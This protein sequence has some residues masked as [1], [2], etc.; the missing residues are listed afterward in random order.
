MVI[1]AID[2][3]SGESS[4]VTIQVIPGQ[5]NPAILDH[6][7]L[8]N[9]EFL[10]WLWD[11]EADFVVI[12]TLASNGGASQEV[13][14]TAY[15]VGRFWTACEFAGK[16]IAG[17]LRRTVARLLLG[18]VKSTDA[19]IIQY[20]SASYGCADHKEAKGTAKNPG[21]LFGIVKH[22]W[23]ALGV[24]LAAI[25]AMRTGQAEASYWDPMQTTRDEFRE[26]KAKRREAKKRRNERRA[27]K[28][29]KG[30]HLQDALDG[31]LGKEKK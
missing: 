28:G 8:P 10:E 31:F 1:I 13:V 16:P 27:E 5:K 19:K 23:Q 9:P 7:D 29:Q 21:P 4:A 6:I 2:P 12:E 30:G 25:K 14:D 24:G 18:Q 20:C 11:A 3:G 15:W 26:K 17:L 22:K